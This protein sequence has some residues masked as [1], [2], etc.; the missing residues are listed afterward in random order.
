MVLKRFSKEKVVQL[1]KMILMTSFDMEKNA[2]NNFKNDTLN[3]E[4]M[5]CRISLPSLLIIGWVKISSKRNRLVWLGY[6]LRNENVIPRIILWIIITRMPCILV[7]LRKP[8]LK[9]PNLLNKSIS[10]ITN[11]IHP[12]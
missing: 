5:S 10:K 6:I 9:L 12:S 4:S 3:W 1:E 11:S 8:D 7:D 2:P